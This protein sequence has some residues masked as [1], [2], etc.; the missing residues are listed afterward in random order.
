MS[1]TE[2]PP[3]KPS[4]A[5][6][7]HLPGLDGLRAI[8]IGV[9]FGFHLSLP[10][11]SLGW[12]GVQLFFVISGF[13]ITGILL[14]S[15]SRPR[16]F[17]NFYIRR[18]LRIFPIYYLVIAIYFVAAYLQGDGATAKLFPYYLTY[19]QTYPQLVTRYASAPLLGHTWTLAIEEQF[20]LLWPLAI[21]L[22][23]GKWLAVA[24]AACVALA[25]GERIVV[26]GFANPFLSLGLLPSQI[27]L[28]A[29]G[30]AIA[31][32]AAARP[33]AWMRR[34][35]YLLAGAGV[36]VAGAMVAHAGLGVFWSAFT[37]VPLPIGPYFPTA[38]AVLFAGIVALT[39][40]RAPLTRWLANRPMMRIGK[41]SYGLYLFHPFVFTWIDRLS[42]P[43]R[44]TGPKSWASRLVVLGIM[45]AKV[46]A[47][48]LVAECSWRFFEGPINALKDRLTRKP[49]PKPKSLARTADLAANQ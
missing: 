43:L 36:V 6:S 49:A 17:R 48:V 13:L 46:G 12:S 1:S 26:H 2:I 39:A 32:L 11:F 22:L 33:V 9:V 23:R 16:Y 31:V 47:T 41:I 8:A 25:L 7:D 10:G 42:A 19:S 37:W 40:T 38:M 44:P 24:L 29:A 5:S 27:D 30:S 15:R 18:T 34:L 35:G 45:A 21:F 28:L 3:P 20:Y 4:A 14:R